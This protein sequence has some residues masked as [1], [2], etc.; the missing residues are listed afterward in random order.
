MSPNNALH[1]DGPRAARPAGERGRWADR[2]GAMT[3]QKDTHPRNVPGPF[4]VVNGCCT[5]CGVPEMAPGIFEFAP[6]GHCYVKGQPS[7]SEGVELALRV[8]RTQELGCI[9]YAGSDPAILRRLAEADEA[10]QCD[11]ELFPREPWRS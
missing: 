9:R 6:E 10:E 11:V 2:K 1:S 7:T 5:T 8:I 4:Y 3:R